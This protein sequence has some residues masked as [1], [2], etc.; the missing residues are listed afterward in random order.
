M[1]KYHVVKYGNEWA[2][3]KA[4]A[5]RVS[6]IHRKQSSAI[7]HGKS[8]TK[9]AG[10][11]ELSIHNRKGQIREKNTYDKKDLFPPKG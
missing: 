7:E 8:F 3:R 2:T 10:G 4:G 5:S 6:S 1:A 9:K 11:G